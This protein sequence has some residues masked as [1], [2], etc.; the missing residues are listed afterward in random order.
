MS[1]NCSVPLG[2]S[3]ADLLTRVARPVLDDPFSAPDE[4]SR[5]DGFLLCE[6]LDAV[7]TDTQIPP[8]F[9]PK[10]AVARPVTFLC[11]LLFALL[12]QAHEMSL[13]VS[14]PLCLFV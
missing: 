13:L 1:C 6:L 10:A 3:Y 14:S 11:S 9:T 7:Q 2:K 12:G 4:T 8:L 5:R